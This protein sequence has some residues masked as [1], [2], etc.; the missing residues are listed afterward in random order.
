MRREMLEARA[1]SLERWNGRQFGH[2][3]CCVLTAGWLFS[4]MA[5]DAAY[6]TRNLS[7]VCTPHH[8]S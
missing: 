6:V 5:K 8:C 7:R 1:G 2:A 4:V 3:G